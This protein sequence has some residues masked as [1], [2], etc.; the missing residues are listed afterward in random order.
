MWPPWGRSRRGKD[1]SPRLPRC[2]SSSPS[3][4]FSF[5]FS[6]LK[7]IDALLSDGPGPGPNST[8]AAA[9]PLLHRAR[10][11]SGSFRSW[12][13]FSSSSPSSSPSFHPDP[14]GLAPGEEKRIVLYFTSLRV[15]RKTFEDCRAVRSILRGFRV[16]VDER[17]L[18]MDSAFLAELKG[19]LGGRRGRDLALPQVFIGGRYIGGADEVRHLHESGELGRFIEGARPAAPGP[20]A[21]A[22]VWASCSAAAAAAAASAS[23]TSAAPSGA[24]ATATRMASCGAP[25][26]PPLPPPTDR[27]RRVRESR[28]RRGGDRM[29]HTRLEGEG[30][31]CMIHLHNPNKEYDYSALR[32]IDKS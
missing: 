5:S 16:A 15:V 29:P 26:A 10:S 24:A 3:S 14:F 13:S 28:D 32:Q 9:P 2:P 20:A 12:R 22:A 21:D 27:D 11:A 25:N 23:A 6:S 19:I 7:D 1:A 17:D 18:S 30:K 4:P 31:A 8:A